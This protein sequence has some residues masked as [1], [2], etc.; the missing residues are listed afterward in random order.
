MTTYRAFRVEKDDDGVRH[1]IVDQ[2]T[3]DLPVG[4][5]LIRVAYSSVNYKDALSAKGMPGVTRAYPHTPGIDAAGTVVDSAVTGFREGDEVICIGFDLGMNTPGGYGEYIRVPAGWLTRLPQGLTLREAM[6]LGTAG[7]TAALCLEKIETMGGKPSDGPVIVTGA[8]G[9]VGSVA[10]ALLANAGYEVIASTG[11][12]DRTEY[13][14]SLGARTVIGREA[15]AAENK[16]PLL[17]TDYAHGIDTVGGEILSNV[18]KSLAYGGSVA[19]CGLVASPNFTTTVLPFILRGVNVLG[20]DS[21]ELPIDEKTRTWNR[22]GSD[23]RL[24]SLESMTREIDLNGISQAV[25][26]I[27][28]GGVTGRTLVIHD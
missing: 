4:E 27:F 20:I 3:D 16:R 6:I 28:A 15:L 19:I 5:V 13:L 22:L 8:T 26:E 23:W 21:V 18:I 1:G 2:D 14:T 25:D 7:F 11:K 17:G 12:E 10:V 24:G 9:G